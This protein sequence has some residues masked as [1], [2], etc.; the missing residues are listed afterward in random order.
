MRTRTD[1]ETDPTLAVFESPDQAEVAIRRLRAL[2]IPPDAIRQT[3]LPRGS[4]QCTDPSLGES[5]AGVLHGAQF[6][7]PA[8][9]ALG[10]GMASVSQV[11]PEVFVWLAGV[12]AV[13]GAVV[14]SI[15]GAAVR[16]HYDDDVAQGI[17]VPDGS[18]AALLLAETH[19]DGTTGRARQVLRRAGALAFLDPNVYADDDAMS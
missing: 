11:G 10:L 4:Y 5:F 6:G 18:S 19:S 9:A 8:G 15:I 7:A 2:G 14:G 1:Y 17:A 12:G 13:M 16:A 3:P